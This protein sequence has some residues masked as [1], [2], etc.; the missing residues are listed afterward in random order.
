MNLEIKERYDSL[1]DR[2]YAVATEK[3]RAYKEVYHEPGSMLGWLFGVLLFVVVFAA[4][5]GAVIVASLNTSTNDF[6]PTT[7]KYKT[8]PNA[9]AILVLLGL[10]ALIVVIS[11][12]YAI[13][14]AGTKSM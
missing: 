4:V 10:V 2:A 13:W 8:F 12:V 6:N 5:F 14:R 11:V 7:G 3:A 1:V 9:A